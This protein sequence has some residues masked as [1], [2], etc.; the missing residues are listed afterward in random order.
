VEKLKSPQTEE[1][2][3]IG[4]GESGE[5]FMI[6]DRSE[7]ELVRS[8]KIRTAL[9]IFGGGGIILTMLLWGVKFI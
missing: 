8:L 4:K 1:V 5:L 2:V 9:A 6:S 7:H 3:F